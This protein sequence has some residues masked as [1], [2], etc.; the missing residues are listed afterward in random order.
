MNTKA[1]RTKLLADLK[2]AAKHCIESVKKNMQQKMKN[3][4]LPCII[5]DANDCWVLSTRDTNRCKCAKA[6]ER[7]L[8]TASYNCKE[9]ER[10]SL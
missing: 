2:S 3:H 4:L 1:R 9:E 8:Q 10:F 6:V 7:K 5:K